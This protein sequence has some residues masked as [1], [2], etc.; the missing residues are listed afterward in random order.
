M[1]SS[2]A[3]DEF[4]L[5]QPSATYLPTMCSKMKGKLQM[6]LGI[7]G[8]LLGKGNLIICQLKKKSNKCRLQS[9][10]FVIAGN[11]MTVLLVKNTK[12]FPK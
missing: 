2:A 1:I 6:S 8:Q 9:R 3:K 5:K 7:S 4:K 12:Q 10:I 11:S